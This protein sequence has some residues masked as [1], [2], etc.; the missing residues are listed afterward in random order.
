MASL[1]DTPVRFLFSLADR[2][3]QLIAAPDVAVSLSFYDVSS[4]PDAVV[5]TTDSRFLWAIEDVRGLYAADVDF[6][7]AGRWGT[8]FDVSFPDDSAATVS[9]S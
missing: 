2:A 6:P 1:S 4:D 5:F 9:R 3:N 7:H 8:R